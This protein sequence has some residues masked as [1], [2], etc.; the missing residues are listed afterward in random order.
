MMSDLRTTFES[1]HP[2]VMLLEATDRDGVEA[3]LLSR[4]L[5]IP[6]DGPARV[7]RAGEGNMNLTLRVSLRGRR[8]ILKQGRPWVEKYDHIA[9]PWG[10]TLVEAGFYRAVEGVPAVGGRLPRLLDVDAQNHVLVLEDLGMC[11]DFTS[12]YQ[13][14]SI[15]DGALR[16]LLAWLSALGKVRA[17]M[18]TEDLAN[19]G[20]RELNHEHI[21]ALPLRDGN[22]LDL[23]GITPGLSSEAEQL[24][25]DAAYVR[26]VEELGDCYLADGPTL[27]HGDYFPGSW[28]RTSAGVRI[29][30]P[31]FCFMGAPEFDYGVLLAHCVLAGADQRHFIEVLGAA[32]VEGLEHD[33][34]LGFAG[35][36][37]MRRLIGV[38]Q[39]PL[40]ADLDR[41]RRLLVMSR[42]MVLEPQRGVACGA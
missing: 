13:G 27:V 20:M 5:A 34:L 24:K 11:G 6:A 1:T 15:S 14:Q 3:Y 29:I 35:V 21:F 26:H 22:D 9:A 28:M 25:N 17:P 19:R 37:I 23:D 32:A 30:D 40:R 7:E 31:E 39:L 33:L 4:C 12:M 10:R 18:L 38:A 41:K 2:D 36:E 16:D 42:S 8:F